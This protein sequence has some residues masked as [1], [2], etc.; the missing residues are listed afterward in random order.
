MT[1]GNI[2]LC[3]KLRAEY[4]NAETM[5]EDTKRKEDDIFSLFLYGLRAY[6]TRLTRT[7]LEIIGE[8]R[9]VTREGCGTTG[10]ALSSRTQLSVR[11]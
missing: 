3:G 6:D 8:K 1:D 7:C 10:R 2:E 11:H 4:G 9:K 5:T